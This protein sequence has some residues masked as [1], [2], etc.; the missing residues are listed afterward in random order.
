MKT[1]KGSGER[2]INWRSVKGDWGSHYLW[3]LDFKFKCRLLRTSTINVKLFKTILQRI[4]WRD[5]R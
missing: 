4:E 2:S 5:A 3:K 1:F